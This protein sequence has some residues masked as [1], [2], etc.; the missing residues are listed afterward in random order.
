VRAFLLPRGRSLARRVAGSTAG[1]AVAFAVARGAA[2]AEPCARVEA[3]AELTPTWQGA[4]DELRA[5]IAR[6]P[7]DECAPVVL[8]VSADASGAR[9]VATAA[10]GRRAER[11][12][13][14]PE[15][16]V[17]TGLGLVMGVAAP[18]AP[19]PVAGPNLP[20]GAPGVAPAAVAPAQAPALL[21]TRRLA[22]WLGLEAG[23][24]TTQ[25]T[26]IAMLDVR[27]FAQLRLDHWLFELALGGAPAALVGSQ[28]IDDDAY[29]EASAALAIGRQIPAGPAT[30]DLSA[31]ASIVSMRMEYD[32]P[33]G[34]ETAGSDVELGFGA[35]ARLVLPLATA[36]ALALSLDAR[37]LPGNVVSASILEEPAGEQAAPPPFPAWSAALR[38]GAMGELL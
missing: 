14:Q 23:G 12:V 7:A 1:A 6:L 27:F 30:V 20:P 9:V 2:G 15:S 35:G 13:A 19:Q 5:Q 3:A 11:R 17:A 22:L 36:W 8:V 26:S 32:Y 28:G 4:V 37:I 34:R 31:E 38:V 29:R 25:P 10:D 21:E 16:L 24:R 33:D 18:P